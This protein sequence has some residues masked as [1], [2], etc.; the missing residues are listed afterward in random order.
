MCRRNL[1]RPLVARGGAVTLGS[2]KMFVLE[3]RELEIRVWTGRH[4]PY[5]YRI[6]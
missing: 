3:K 5:V 2:G 4:N 6:W 1:E